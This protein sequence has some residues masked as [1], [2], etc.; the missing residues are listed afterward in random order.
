METPPL[1]KRFYEEAVTRQNDAG[2]WHIALDGRPAKT[3]AGNLLASPSGALAEAM[4]AEWQAQAE[5]ID[6]RTM[7]LTRRRMLVI[8]RGEKDSPKWR[9]QV[10]AFLSSD[11]LCYRADTPE[12]LVQRQK[13]T[14]DPYLTWAATDL[15]IRLEVTAGVISVSQP[16]VSLQAA[17]NVLNRADTD[18]LCCIIAATEIT[19]SAILGLA[20]WQRFQSTDDVFAA[21][22]LDETFQAEKWGIDAEAAAR[23]A[24]LKSDLE[25]VAA[26]LDGCH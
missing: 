6:P 5:H 7:P 10:L 2:D 4:A 1:P 3:S 11:L 18:E 17:G 25:A 13:E 12:E 26:Y 23:E 8:D 9:D 15:D 20:L 19:G 24:Q 16:P 22:R 21:S 14:W